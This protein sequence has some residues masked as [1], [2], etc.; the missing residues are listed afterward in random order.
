MIIDSL[1]TIILLEFECGV[2]TNHITVWFHK[3]FG[4][5]L[6]QLLNSIT[7][8]IPGYALIA[9]IIGLA[10]AIVW[11]FIA[12]NRLKNEKLETKIKKETLKNLQSDDTNPA[13]K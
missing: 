11:L 12:I 8:D 9:G 6:G 1:S 4:L 5:I 10:G 13:N 2:E 3:K 7:F